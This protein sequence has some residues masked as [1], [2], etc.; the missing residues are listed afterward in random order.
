MTSEEEAG[1]EPSLKYHTNNRRRR[2]TFGGVFRVLTLRAPKAQSARRTR[3][4][5]L[6]RRQDKTLS[7]F[8]LSLVRIACRRDDKTRPYPEFF[9][10]L[11][12]VCVLSCLVPKHDKRLMPPCGLLVPQFLIDRS[13]SWRKKNH[14]KKMKKFSFSCTVFCLRQ[15]PVYCLIF[16]FL[17]WV[18]KTSYNMIIYYTVYYISSFCGIQQHNNN[19]NMSKNDERLMQ[20][21]A[22]YNDQGSKYQ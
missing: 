7:R 4:L 18:F 6:R 11:T 14:D 1:A 22:N 19:N 16:F 5:V 20:I 13:G 17:Q 3:N 12:P 9:I 10:S 15:V 8:L 21:K 2:K